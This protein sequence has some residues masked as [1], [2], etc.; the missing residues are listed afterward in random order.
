MI[1]IWLELEPG[2]LLSLQKK[3]AYTDLIAFVFIVDE[4][5]EDHGPGTFEE[6]MA[7]ANKERWLLAMK[8]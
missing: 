7:S 2:E 1:I 8:E 5:I 3:Y 6:A 4:K